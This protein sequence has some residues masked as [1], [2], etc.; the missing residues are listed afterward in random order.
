MGLVQGGTTP[1]AAGEAV[2]LMH[3]LISI[4][5]RYIF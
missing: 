5:G 1:L 3:I 4:R 2:T